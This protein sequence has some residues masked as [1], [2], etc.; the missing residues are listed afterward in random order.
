MAK[1]GVQEFRVEIDG[2]DLPDEVLQRIDDAVRKAV[3]GELA[4]VNFG[5]R[6]V[7]LLRAGLAV[8]RIGE[9]GDPQ[10]IRVRQV[11]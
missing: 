6:G 7:D 2:I 11:R 5:G 10:G 4:T 8:D 1:D 9:G 3:L